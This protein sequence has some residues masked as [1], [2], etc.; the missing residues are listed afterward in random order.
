[1]T[2][3]APN[4]CIIAE[5]GVNHNGDPD[6]A[7][8]LVDA[9]AECGADVVKFQTFT[10]S[11]VV[12]DSAPRAPYQIVNTGETSSQ[13]DMIKHLELSHETHKS[14]MAHCASKKLEFLSTP[15]DHASLA[16]LHE[17]LD[18]ARIKFGSGE[19]TN[20][21][22]LLATGQTG[23]PVILSTGMATLDDVEAALGALAFGYLN[24][25]SPSNEGFKQ[26]YKDSA[27]QKLLKENV[28]LLHCTTA[29]PT[30]FGDVN[31]RAM[32]TM[33]ESFDLPVGFSDHTKG[34]EIAVAAVAMGACIIEKHL[35]LDQSLPGPDHKASLEPS[36]FKAMVSA[37]RSVEEAMGNGDKAPQAAEKPNIAIARKSLIALRPIQAGEQFTTKNLGI[38]RPGSGK[39][40]FL[41]WDLIGQ[42]ADKNYDQDDLIQ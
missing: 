13:I 33:K 40:P 30:P 31:L 38:K 35:T 36:E 3:K 12:T 34:I 25:K 22:L 27:G 15:F 41:Y 19:L 9:A 16:F 10:A 11:A 42:S 4:T 26:A 7:R 2:N 24:M 37:I 23:K 18:L 1:M 29:Y 8:A 32:Q 28:I 20:A 5:A 14:L 6:M 21:P 17:Q 39:S